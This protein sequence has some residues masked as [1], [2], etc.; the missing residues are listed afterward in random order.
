MGSNL[1]SRLS[2]ARSGGWG[3]DQALPPQA[4]RPWLRSAHR[5]HR[6]AARP[7][8]VGGVALLVLCA[9]LLL[10]L[11][12]PL[13]WR[14]DP[15]TTNL[16]GTFAGPS[17]AHPLGTDE[18]GRD[19]LSRLLHGGRRSLGGAVVVL[20]GGL[21][22]G[23][24]AGALAGML[25]GRTDALLSRLIDGLLAL[26]TLVL[27]FALVGVLG[28]SFGNLLLALTLAHWP[29]YA[30]ICR[31]LVLRER[32]QDYVLAAQTLGVPVTRIVW[33]HIGPNILGPILV[34]ISTS[35]G[36]AILSLTA[37][38]FLGLGVQP[39]TAEWGAMVS[40]ARPYF[41]TNPWV[42]AAPG[43]AISATVVALTMLGD[44][45]RDAAD[46]RLA[47]RAGSDTTFD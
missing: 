43:L 31:S 2:K 39:P 21:G 26:P 11:A 17:A 9:I 32:H 37:L 25:G 1:H 42:I 30:R 19:I 10:V 12:G 34:L 44:A 22:I 20:A 46:P 16:A 47:H 7:R 14:A 6:W 36:G 18:L 3:Q 40:S 33:R 24:L 5:Q 41:Q 23:L 38:S 4:Q 15:D 29:W 8:L 45:L 35:L 27:A 28:R 13:V